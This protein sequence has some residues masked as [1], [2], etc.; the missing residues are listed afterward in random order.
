M[1]CASPLSIVNPSKVLSLDGGTPFV[2]SVPCGKCS[3]CRQ[4]A[5]DEYYFRSYYQALST[6]HKGGFVQAVALTYR[7]SCLPHLSNFFNNISKDGSLDFPC[8]NR[9]D[10]RLFIL[11]LREHLA[12]L[13]Y[14]VKGKFQYFLVSEYGSALGCTHRPHYHVLFYV[15]F[16]IDPLDFSRIVGKCWQLGISDTFPF[17]PAS[18]VRHYTFGYKYCA[19]TFAMQKKCMYV[20]KYVLKSSIFEKTLHKRII[21]IISRDYNLSGADLFN[22]L[23]Y[24]GRSVYMQYYNQVKQ[25]H[26]QSNGFGSCLFD[27]NNIDDVLKTGMISIRDSHCVVRH[28]PLPMYYR[29]RLFYDLTKD[30][31]GVRTWQI[32]D[33]GKYWLLNRRLDSVKRLS[34]TFSDWFQNLR[35]YMPSPSDLLTS[36]DVDAFYS[37]MVSRVMGLLGDRSWLDF[38]TYISIYKGRIKS[39]DQIFREFLG[40]PSIDGLETWACNVIPDDPYKGKWLTY[41]YCTSKDYDLFGSRFVCSDWL[42]DLQVGILPNLKLRKRSDNTMLLRDFLKYYVI[43][44][45]SDPRFKGFDELYSI[46][47][48]TSCWRSGSLIAAEELRAFL[49]DKFA[50]K[51]VHV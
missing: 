11:R 20:S 3:K 38:A 15:L 4:T 30:F 8:F 43:D 23:Q 13:G 16:D 45:S 26:R 40:S 37:R 36:S 19:D 17:K 5:H 48:E 47:C 12:R 50:Q 6:F 31:R 49:D 51:A 35:S 25:F 22:F 41:N 46:Y 39:D 34:R 7:D 33:L 29:R 14:D 27:F 18:Y 28:I 1:A 9:R 42:G 10:V 21:S 44:D 2:L 24:D 32:N